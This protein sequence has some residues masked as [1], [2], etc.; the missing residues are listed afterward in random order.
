MDGFVV[1][2][3]AP[4]VRVRA[5]REMLPLAADLDRTIDHLWHMAV[6]RVAA[7]GAGQ[8]FNGRVFSADSITPTEIAGH[9]T[10]FRRIVAQMEDPAL[11]SDLALRPLAVCGV[12]HGPAGVAIGRRPAAAIYQPGLWQLPPAGS[13]D[14]QALRPDGTL[15]LRAQLMTEL[16][17]ELGLDPA[18]VFAERP[19]CLVEHPGSHVS[20]LGI[21]VCTNLPEEAILSAHRTRGNGEYDPLR[22]IGHADLASLIARLG[23]RLVPPARAFLV[24]AGLLTTDGRPHSAAPQPAVASPTI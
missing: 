22:I 20:D 15:D 17:E 14:A 13:V 16:H 1:H 21:S 3:I 18:D 7:G 10:E 4:T 6:R 2:E 8:L 12:L 24:H 9:M 23:D 19:L 11:F 5:V